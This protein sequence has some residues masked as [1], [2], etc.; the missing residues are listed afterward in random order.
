MLTLYTEGV[1]ECALGRTQPWA[2]ADR[3]DEIK[4]L[5]TTKPCGMSDFLCDGK[6]F[7]EPSRVSAT[8]VQ[9]P[10]PQQDHATAVLV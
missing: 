4:S 6:G 5:E 7:G 2:L 1:S 9:A 8:T 3:Q 10:H